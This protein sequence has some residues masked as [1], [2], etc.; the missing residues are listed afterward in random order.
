[1]GNSGVGSG[2]IGAVEEQHNYRTL[3]NDSINMRAINK[4][5]PPTQ[6]SAARDTV[7]PPCVSRVSFHMSVLHVFLPCAAQFPHHSYVTILF[8]KNCSVL[9]SSVLQTWRDPGTLVPLLTHDGDCS[10]FRAAFAL[11]ASNPD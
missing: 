8:R 10:T 5:A 4:F 3:H 2:S 7:F 9:N 6:A 1:M 11:T